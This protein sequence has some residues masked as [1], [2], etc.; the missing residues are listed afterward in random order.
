M[1]SESGVG[2]SQR[3][4]SFSVKMNAN[5]IEL[6]FRPKRM[7][8]VSSPSEYWRMRTVRRS[9]AF[10]ALLTFNV[11]AGDLV[12]VPIAR[13]GSCPSGYSSSG[14]YCRPSENARFA[15]EKVGSCPSGYSSSGNYC[16]ASSNAKLAIPKVGTCPSGYHSSGDYCLANK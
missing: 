10:L 8:V 6:N 2:V 16:L 3:N 4:E 11:L 9:Q 14:S 12:A 15:I 5:E 1:K 13:Q 7:H